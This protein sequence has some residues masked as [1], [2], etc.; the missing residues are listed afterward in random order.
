M[1]KIF[2]HIH[3]K[4]C[5]ASVHRLQ[6]HANIILCGWLFMVGARPKRVPPYKCN[7]AHCRGSMLMDVCKRYFWE[8]D[9]VIMHGRAICRSPRS[10]RSRFLYIG[11]GG[12]S[13]VHFYSVKFHILFEKPAFGRIRTVRCYVY[14]FYCSPSF[15]RD[16]P[17]FPSGH[18]NLP[19][20]VQ[21][22]N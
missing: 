18:I 1:W 17:F 6:A 9:F 13:R 3:R 19:L 10:H 20:C 16:Q 22:K 14:F 7:T 5:R 21:T 2:L 11:K 4:R 15:E 8:M 12:F